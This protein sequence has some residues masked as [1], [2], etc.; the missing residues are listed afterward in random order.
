[1]YT[2]IKTLQTCDN[3]YH[4]VK[5][6]GIVLTSKIRPRWL[7]NFIKSVNVKFS[8]LGH[9]NYLIPP[10]LNTKLGFLVNLWV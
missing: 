8:T 5:R 2:V 7:L 3:F 10:L 4:V 6:T 9:W 1:M